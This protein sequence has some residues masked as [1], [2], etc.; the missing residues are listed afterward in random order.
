V[1]RPIKG[2]HLKVH[3]KSTEAAIKSDCA[4]GA[5][6]SLKLR[7]RRAKYEISLD[8]RN[9]K[10]RQREDEI[11]RL[12]YNSDILIIS[13][14]VISACWFSLIFLSLFSLLPLP[15]GPP[16]PRSLLLLSRL[17]DNKGKLATN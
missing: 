6:K 5:R 12:F 3:D 9:H 7:R 14:L 15:P 16:Q 8:G 4:K 10:K 2:K 1:Q 13:F 11:S 17:S